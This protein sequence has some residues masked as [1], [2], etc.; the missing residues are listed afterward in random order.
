M[1]TTTYSPPQRS[2][3]QRRQALL[4]AN[5]TRQRRAA[6]KRDLKAG[7][8][9]L[10]S[11]LEYPTPDWLATMKLVDVLLAT[12]KLGRVKAH[13][14]MLA[15]QISPSKTVSGLTWRQREQLTAALVLRRIG[16][17]EGERD[18]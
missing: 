14:V 8:C 5:E 4:V 9:S 7:R 16:G 15:A 18:D 2:T 13:R 3:D 1:S 10:A 17:G 11:V 12:P 6:L